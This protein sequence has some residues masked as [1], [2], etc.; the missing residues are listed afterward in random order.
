MIQ[1][2]K[3]CGSAF[4]RVDK[5][6]RVEDEGR[7]D[8][9]AGSPRRGVR[10]RAYFVFQGD[11]LVGAARATRADDAAARGVRDATVDV[12]VVVGGARRVVGG[13]SG[14]GIDGGGGELF[15]L[16]GVD[17]VP[18]GGTP[19][20]ARGRAGLGAAVGSF[21]LSRAVVVVRRLRGGAGALLELAALVLHAPVLR[22]HQFGAF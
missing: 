5:G 13:D 18:R 2:M 10:R 16:Q 6:R 7:R 19:A 14:R 20:M 1:E 12:G 8:G 3:G 17:G 4:G 22:M 11:L 9:T 21:E 15:A